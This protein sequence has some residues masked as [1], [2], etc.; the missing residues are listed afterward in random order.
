MVTPTAAQAHYVPL[1]D[2]RRLSYFTAGPADGYPVVY[3]HGAIG[4]PR[5]RV[6]GLDETLEQL[7]VRYLIVNRP[8]FSGSDPHPGRA[9]I[10]FAGDVGHAMTVL[11]HDRFSVLGVSAG[12]PYAL[13]CG[14]ALPARVARVAA[15]SPLGPRAGAGAS[16]SPRY[17]LP[18]VAFGAPGV[19]SG[20]AALW[21]HALRL[22]RYTSSRA[23]VA[24]FRVCR[25]A[26]GF[27]LGEVGVPTSV[28][29]GRADRVVPLSH[30]RLLAA[31]IP[32]AALSVEPRGG[33][34][35][36]PRRIREIVGS[37]VPGEPERRELEP[38]TLAGAV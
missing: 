33:H 20:L 16:R 35:F 12:A 22:R 31:A 2:G 24:D 18:L 28:W 17:A 23:M 37:L 15:V 11:G 25:R 7:R 9:V 3:F 29:H 19:G 36:Y 32:G 8:G 34:F 5:W 13:A 38:P 1:P 10:D 26:W 27:D 4:S 14:W 30:V 21:L 6:P